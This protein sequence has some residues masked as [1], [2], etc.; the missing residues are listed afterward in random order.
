[1]KKILFILCML[2]L[3]LI[4]CEEYNECNKDFYIYEQEPV[5]VRGLV[6]FSNA[7]RQDLKIDTNIINS[8]NL[9]YVNDYYYNDDFVYN[10]GGTVYYP[11]GSNFTQNEFQENLNQNGYYAFI[12]EDTD[13]SFIYY[14]YN[15]AVE[16]GIGFLFDTE[17]INIYDTNNNFI[18][19]I[20]NNLSLIA[21]ADFSLEEKG[22]VCGETVYYANKDDLVITILLEDS[23]FTNTVMG[24]TNK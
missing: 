21:E 20:T 17:N 10:N 14:F 3:L 9:P 22:E 12:I 4:A 18:Y 2:F 5:K 11:S 24:T 16:E 15:R 1:M 23:L 13:G 8:I 6:V 7:T 19:R